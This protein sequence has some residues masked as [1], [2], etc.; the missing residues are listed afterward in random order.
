MHDFVKSNLHLIYP[1]LNLERMTNYHM[2]LMK[3][4]FTQWMR[5]SISS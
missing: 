1:L 2:T 5:L 4:L 3:N